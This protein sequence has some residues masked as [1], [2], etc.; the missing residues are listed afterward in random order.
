MEDRGDAL[1]FAKRRL[2]LTAACSL[3]FPLCPYST[4]FMFYHKLVGAIISLAGSSLKEASLPC[5]SPFPSP[6]SAPSRAIAQNGSKRVFVEP[7]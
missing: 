3:L 4:R 1:L 6:F 2:Q 5:S 7:D